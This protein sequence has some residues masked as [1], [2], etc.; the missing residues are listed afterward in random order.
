M[1]PLFL[2]PP[3]LELETTGLVCSLVLPRGFLFRLLLVSG[4]MLAGL[5]SSVVNIRDFLPASA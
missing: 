4:S 3:P 1:E 2:V 5:S